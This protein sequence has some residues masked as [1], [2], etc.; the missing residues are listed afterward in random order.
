MG[1]YCGMLLWNATVECPYGTPYAFRHL[2]R[3]PAHASTRHEDAE[4]R[5]AAPPPL[6]LDPPQRTQHGAVRLG[7]SL[8]TARALV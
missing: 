2:P 7:A 4:C 6:P 5:S 1:C 3:K 8:R